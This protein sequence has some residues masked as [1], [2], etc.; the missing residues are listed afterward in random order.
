MRIDC[1]LPVK[2][3]VT[4]LVSSVSKNTSLSW[5]VPT[6]LNVFLTPFL[7]DRSS[8]RSVKKSVHAL[9]QS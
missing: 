7:S 8:I 2:G 5:A 4:T 3:C 1:L 6:N 9:F